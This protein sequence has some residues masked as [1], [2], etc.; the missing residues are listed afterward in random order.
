MR[1]HTSLNQ[2]HA[3][4]VTAFVPEFCGYI[5]VAFRTDNGFGILF[6]KGPII[7]WQVSNGSLV[8]Q[9]SCG[10]EII[11]DFVFDINQ[12]SFIALNGKPLR[13]TTQESDLPSVEIGFFF[14]RLAKC[15][16]FVGEPMQGEVSF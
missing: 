8:A 13:T 4:H 7:D 2:A 16:T 14:Y 12:S 11:T 15:L 5:L 6:S 10:I 9:A 1:V 3:L